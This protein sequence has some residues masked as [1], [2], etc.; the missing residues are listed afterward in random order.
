MSILRPPGRHSVV[1]VSAWGEFV[2]IAAREVLACLHRG[3][4]GLLARGPVMVHYATLATDPIPAAL[5]AIED[6][7]DVQVTVMPQQPSTPQEHRTLQGYAEA[8]GFDVARR[9]QADW[10]P[11]CADHVF[12][13]EHLG[14]VKQLLIDGKRAVV[15]TALRGRREAWAGEPPVNAAALVR[16]TLDSLH[17]SMRAYVMTDPPRRLIANPHLMIFERAGEM[18]V[19]QGQVA[20]FGV[21]RDYV[22]ARIEQMQDCRLLADLQMEHGAGCVRFVTD[23]ALDGIALTSLEG[24]DPAV[25]GDFEQTPAELVRTAKIFCTRAWDLAHWHWALSH[26]T[27]YPFAWGADRGEQH[28]D[29]DQAVAEALRGLA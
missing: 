28:L 1:H 8:A 4:G 16:W 6:L 9:F 21:A 20:V 26:R 14:N 5:R 10:F 7:C 11:L 27:V 19:R 25:F 24:D 3:L 23:P 2:P 29:E 22:G 18:V 15:G 17:P 13:R 12:P